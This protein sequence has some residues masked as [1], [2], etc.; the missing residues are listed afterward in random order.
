MTI[1]IVATVSAIVGGVIGF[2]SHKRI[3]AED[4]KIAIAVKKL[5][6]DK[7]TASVPIK[8]SE[9]VTA[10]VPEEKK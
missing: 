2:L 3:V 5:L 10:V 1:E 9:I 7:I 8:K 6:G 4:I